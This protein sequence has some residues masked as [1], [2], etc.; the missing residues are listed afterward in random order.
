VSIG[1]KIQRKVKVEV[2]KHPK[3][4]ES[5]SVSRRLAWGHLSIDQELGNIVV[6]FQF[7]N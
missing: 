6:G 7:E 1:Q 5:K 2:L 4:E 3:P